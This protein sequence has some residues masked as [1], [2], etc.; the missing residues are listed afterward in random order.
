MITLLTG[1]DHAL[2]ISK[3]RALKSAFLAHHTNGQVVEFDFSDDASARRLKVVYEASESDLFS[4][5]KC[6][7]LD[8][9]SMFTEDIRKALISLITEKSEQVE[10]IL[11]EP[12]NL[13]KTEL[14]TK[15]LL[16]L[17]KIEVV[18]AEIP[19]D[20][21]RKKLIGELLSTAPEELRLNQKA[22]VL[23]LERVGK[24]TAKL[25][26]EIEKLIVYKGSGVITVEDVELLLEPTLE[27]TAF[28]ALD[29]LAKGE[30]EKA[31]LLFHN[32][33]LWKKDA[34]PIL[35]LC[36]WQIRQLILLREVY[37][38]G[39]RQD[40]ILANQ[41]GVSPF[42]ASKLSRVLE[43]FPLSRLKQA[44]A[45]IREYDSGIKRGLIEQGVAIDLLAWKI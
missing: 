28:L 16:S 8:T 6:L 13:K 23:F 7:I 4:Q 10:W 18:H 42:V 9:P 17:P 43:S 40:R 36:T 15:A 45:L 5:P 20:D 32:A 12:G 22:T 25:E 26:S 35:G 39:V 33:F 24:D 31:T 41:S 34:L 29:A 1:P 38:T 27:D 2:L 21:E 14:Y 37:D 3:K 30:R 44:H 19:S 11:I